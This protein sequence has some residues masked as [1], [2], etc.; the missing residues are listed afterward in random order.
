MC[1][2]EDEIILAECSDEEEFKLGNSHKSVWCPKLEE[3]EGLYKTVKANKILELEW[4]CTGRRD[5]NENTHEI[6]AEVENC[7]IVPTTKDSEADDFDFEVEEELPKMKSA[8]KPG[9]M[10]KAKSSTKKTTTLAGILSNMERHR[11]IDKMEQ[12]QPSSVPNN[13]NS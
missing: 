2:Q 11:I 10:F 5:P 9:P 12:P 6:T 7:Q 1:S 13:P 4:R 3:I 8:T